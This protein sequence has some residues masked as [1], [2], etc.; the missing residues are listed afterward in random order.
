MNPSRL[1]AAVVAE[2]ISWIREML[3]RLRALPLESYEAVYRDDSA[4]T[5]RGAV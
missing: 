3:A 4:F 2:R 5:P 1:R